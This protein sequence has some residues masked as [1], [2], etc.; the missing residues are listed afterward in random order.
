MHDLRAVD[1]EKRSAGPYAGERDDEECHPGTGAGARAETIGERI[2][3][4]A[5]WRRGKQLWVSGGGT[6]GFRD[7]KRLVAGA[8]ER[9]VGRHVE[10]VC[11]DP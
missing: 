6:D 5:R 7:A 2:E 3:P 9:D 10:V 1:A 11:R 8:A 4:S